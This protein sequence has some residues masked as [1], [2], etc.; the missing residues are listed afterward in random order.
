MQFELVG[1]PYTSMAEPGGIARAIDVL[2]SAGLIGR[3][4]A[5]GDVQDAGDLAPIQGDG[6][7]GPSRLLNE[8]ALARLV[9]ATREAVAS[10][11]E[12][13]RVP[14][15]VGGDCPVLLGALA[16]TRD[17]HGACGLMLVDG[18]EDAWPPSLSPTGEASDS[19]VGVA[20]GLVDDALPEPLGELVPLVKPESV[21]LL[22][23]RD[24][25]EIDDAGAASLEGTVAVF[26]DDDAVRARGPSAS[27]REAAA[28]IGIAAPAFWLHVDLDVLRTEDLAAVDYPQPGGLTWQELRDLGASALSAPGCSGASIVIYNPDKDHD[29]HGA[30][31]IV[32]FAADLV[33]D[34]T[35]STSPLTQ[36]QMLRPRA[37]DST[38]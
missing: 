25:R 4:Q 21:A 16:A 26:L 1:V 20:L 35:P 33:A 7:R 37:R 11:H 36:R 18:H 9:V 19:E 38:A 24:R 12:R 28:A 29:R 13:H 10:S 31:R 3:L 27:A 17:R 32:R 6:V 22:G 15:L 8:A 14:L 34:A 2:R 30:E 23:P 5:A